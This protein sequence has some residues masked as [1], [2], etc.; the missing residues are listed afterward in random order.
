MR[1]GRRVR[2]R[3]SGRTACAGVDTTP[4]PLGPASSMPSSSASATSSSCG[5]AA[6]LAG[7]AV[8][9]RGQE[10]GPDALGRARPAAGRGWPSAGVHTNTRS[11][12]AVGQ[13]LDRRRRS[14]RRAP[15]G[16]RGWW[17]RPGPRSR[18]PAGCGATTKPNL[19][20]WVDAPAI[21][22]PRGSNRARNCSS[23]QR[24]RTVNG[25]APPA[26]RRRR[27]TPSTTIS[28]LTSTDA[29]SGR[30]VGQRP[31]ARPARRPA[32]SRSTAGSPR[33]GPSSAWV[34]R[35]SIMSS[36]STRVERHRAEHRRRRRPRRGCRRRRA[37]RSGRTA[38]RARARRS[39]PG[40]RAPSA[41]PAARPSPSSGR[42]AASSSA[43][44]ARTASASP[45]R[46]RTSPRSVL[47][48]I[49]SPHSLTT[50]GK[51]SASAAAT[52]ASASCTSRLVDDGHPVGAPAAPS[53][54]PRTGW[55]PGW[56]RR[57]TLATAE[58]AAQGTSA[59]RKNV[60]DVAEALGQRVG[61]ERVEVEE[62]LQEGRVAEVAQQRAV[63]R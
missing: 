10:R 41:R 29:T 3:R 63:R 61:V 57:A 34:P 11:A 12:C 62:P 6:L 17:R 50:T 60:D 9:G 30:A 13:L 53:S 59:A 55:D 58:R 16:P 26:R 2:G 7:L 37:S 36:A 23:V 52:A 54:R 1:P 40:S 31:T 8:A 45:S 43:A 19:P 35:S 24:R 22:T 15:P 20:G 14:G 56:A 32:R 46:R 42:A 4:W 49:A 18:R 25:P 44:A 5:P 21:T 33:N 27:G 48:A 51:P 47:C 38:G 28:G 39:A